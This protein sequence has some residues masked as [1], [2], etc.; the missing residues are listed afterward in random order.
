MHD[1]AG[2]PETL[3]HFCVCEVHVF[4]RIMSTHVR[5]SLHACD[6]FSSGVFVWTKVLYSNASIHAIVG[7]LERSGERS[8]DRPSARA[9]GRIAHEAIKRA[10]ERASENKAKAKPVELDR[11]RRGFWAK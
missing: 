9:N 10:I 2:F 7:A 8:G 6:V 3:L 1:Q 5:M 4:K 11:E